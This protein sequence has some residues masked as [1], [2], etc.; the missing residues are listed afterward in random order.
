MDFKKI[1][2]FFGTRPTC[3]FEVLCSILFG[4]DRR[5]I[6]ANR[7]VMDGIHDTV[8]LLVIMVLKYILCS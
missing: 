2:C 3:V 4:S 8:L 5:F 6:T 7:R 1:L